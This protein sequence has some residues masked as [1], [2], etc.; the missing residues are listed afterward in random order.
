MFLGKYKNDYKDNEYL[1]NYY[2]LPF[3]K[4]QKFRS[5]LTNLGFAMFF[6]IMFLVMGTINPP[7]SRTLYVVMPYMFLFLP[8]AYFFFGALRYFQAPER[9]ERIDYRKGLVRMKNSARG[10]IILLGLCVILDLVFIFTHIGLYPMGKEVVYL[11]LHFVFA[12]FVI[13]YGVLYDRLY[14]GVQA[15]IN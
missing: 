4:G 1:G 12:G 5:G 11:A 15:D 7:S 13:A 2:T 8:I 6:A 9:M 3:D 14:G 10:L